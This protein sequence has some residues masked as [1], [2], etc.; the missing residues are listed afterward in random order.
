MI[1]NIIETLQ[2][3]EFYGA[4]ECTETAKG[5]K[6]LRTDIRGIKNKMVRVWKSRRQ[7]K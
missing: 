2:S 1:A 4:G 6:E 3:K 5:D 7:S